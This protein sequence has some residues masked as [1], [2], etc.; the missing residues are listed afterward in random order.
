MYFFPSSLPGVLKNKFI[1]LFVYKYQN[2]EAKR[3]VFQNI[4]FILFNLM[5]YTAHLYVLLF[6]FILFA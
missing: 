3:N 2:Y 6:L 4:W 1:I 5:L